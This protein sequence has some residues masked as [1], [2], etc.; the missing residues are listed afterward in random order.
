LS[1]KI[2]NRFFVRTLCQSSVLNGKNRILLEDHNLKV[3]SFGGLLSVSSGVGVSVKPVNTMEDL[4][5]DKASVKVYGSSKDLKDKCAIEVKQEGHKLSVNA[6]NKDGDQHAHDFKCVIEV[7]LVH[8]VNIVGTGSAPIK[9]Q[10]MVE[11]NYC[12]VTSEE[13]EV[14]IKGVKTA[15]LI[16]QS[17]SGD[18]FCNGSIQGSISIAT[19]EGNVINDKRFLGP[20]LDITTDSG[21]IRVASCYSDQSK[22]STNTGNLFLRNLHN[23][24]YVAVY[25]K[26]NVTMQG[27]DGSTNVF[28]KEGDADIQVSKVGHESRIHVE[29]GD[30]TVKLTDT[31][32]V[33]VCVTANEII[34]DTKFSQYGSI[35]DKKYDD[36]YKHYAGTIH[37]EKFSPTLQVIA[38]NGRVIVESQDWASSLGFKLPGGIDLP[39]DLNIKHAN[40]SEY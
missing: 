5:M 33:K 19:G 23:E 10:D 6:S 32:P 4:H 16:V 30:I 8:N 34:L 7:P 20:S 37:P 11:S 3:P 39:Y 31:F 26:G 18:V 40:L 29:E 9:C 25:E 15:N 21:D 27:V 17:Q 38:E 35:D 14:T 12:H 22:F 2:D 13:G 24:S 1:R 36:G 28:V